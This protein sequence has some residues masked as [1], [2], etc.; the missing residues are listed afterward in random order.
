M[1]VYFI[2]AGPG[3]ADLIT[4]R[5]QRLLER[6]PVCLYAG[7]IMPDDLL[8]ICPP[9]AKVIDTGP[10]TLE[11]IIDELADADAAGHDVAR[12]HSGDPSLY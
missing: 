9:D 2:G 5:G 6:C 11:Q 10:L 4:V 8:A 12:L 1:T 7:S 3:A